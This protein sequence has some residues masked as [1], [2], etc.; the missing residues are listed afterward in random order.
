VEVGEAR[1]RGHACSPAPLA[2][3]VA[4]RASQRGPGGGVRCPR[5]PDGTG[6]RAGL[7][8][9]AA[10]AVAAAGAAGP[11]RPAGP[12][13]APGT[14]VW[15]P[16]APALAGGVA[17]RRTRLLIAVPGSSA[18]PP[19]RGS[20]AGDPAVPAL[21]PPLAALLPLPR[22]ASAARLS[23]VTRPCAACGG[24]VG[25]R[26]QRGTGARG[27]GPGPVDG[28]DADAHPATPCAG[29]ADG[30]GEG[31]REGRPTGPAA[32][33]PAPASRPLPAAGAGAAPPPGAARHCRAPCPGG[34][35]PIPSP[36]S[37]APSPTGNSSSRSPP[38]PWR[39]PGPPPGA[40]PVGGGWGAARPAAPSP[41]VALEAD[42]LRPA[43]GASRGVGETE[44]EELQT[45]AAEG[46]PGATDEAPDLVQPV[47][48]RPR[49]TTGS[50]PPKAAP[51]QPPPA[52]PPAPAPSRV[53]RATAAAATA[54]PPAGRPAAQPAPS[55]EG[56]PCCRGPGPPAP[57][58]WALPVEAAEEA[59]GVADGRV[60]AAAAATAASAAA[61]ALLA[62]AAAALLNWPLP[63]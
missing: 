38:G 57:P 45:E 1:L 44:L 13:G 51:P 56:G 3:G 41:L 29:W 47:A 8:A 5:A 43:S 40:L 60:A 48:H 11:A 17:E 25:R 37:P 10:R 23:A 27:S 7:P 9:D 16:A 46:A 21:L 52:L 53:L 49:P 42:G 61:F 36:T 54:G 58:P 12:A 26:P 39:R 34:G 62:G 15:A 59:S 6:A 30:S 24:A 22:G 63:F 28:G 2:P 55:R 35:A 33:A 4:C 20:R 18:V 32:A 14:P 19:A 31:M 50:A